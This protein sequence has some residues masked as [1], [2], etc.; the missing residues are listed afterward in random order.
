MVNVCKFC[1][2]IWNFFEVNINLQFLRGHIT[3]L[4]KSVFTS[5]VDTLLDATYR[6]THWVEP[7]HIIKVIKGTG[8]Q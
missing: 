3:T 8:A 7:L 5:T 6:R 1:L 4:L 2:S